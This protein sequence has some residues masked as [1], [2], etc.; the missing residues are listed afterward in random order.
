M[1]L[2]MVRYYPSIAGGAWSATP[3]QLRR[4]SAL[5]VH[6]VHAL[7]ILLTEHDGGE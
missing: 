5:A 3:A 2:A 1:A 6:E 4:W 7:D